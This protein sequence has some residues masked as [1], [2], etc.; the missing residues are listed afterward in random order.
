MFDKLM[1]WKSKHQNELKVHRDDSS[2]RR[3]QQD[4][5][6]LWDQMWDDWGH[7]RLS[8][9]ND[10]GLIGS[11]VDWED[12]D[13]EYLVRA[14][15]PGFEPEDFDVKISGNLVTIRAEHKQEGEENG[16]RFRRYGSF[17]ESFRLP[18]AV[19][20]ESIDARYHSG[21][22]EL[23]LPKDENAKGRRIEVKG[24]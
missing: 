15:L 13:H 6:R 23:H 2:L 24:N 17:Y 22:L 1:P 14:E 9:W 18:A 12:H 11:R 4:F 21:V 8:Q 7:N 20:S 19:N 16:G 10:S 3:W 5:N